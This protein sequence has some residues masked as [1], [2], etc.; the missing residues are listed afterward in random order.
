MVLF[1]LNSHPATN[2]DES[3]MV[4]YWSNINGKTRQLL[5]AKCLNIYAARKNKIA[6]SSKKS[7]KSMNL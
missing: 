3:N 1:M 4:V 7:L 5:S 2:S 6:T